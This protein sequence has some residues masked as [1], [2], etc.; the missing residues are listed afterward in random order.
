MPEF[1]RGTYTS[2]IVSGFLFGVGFH[3]AGAVIS[4]LVARF[5]RKA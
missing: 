2:M 4:A 3:L 5:S 1:L